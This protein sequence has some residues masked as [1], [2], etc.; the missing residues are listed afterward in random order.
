MCTADRMKDRLDNQI[1]SGSEL[2]QPILERRPGSSDAKLLIIVCNEGSA[3]ALSGLIEPMQFANQTLGY[4][5]YSWTVAGYPG[6][7]VRMNI[8]LDLCCEAPWN[9]EKP[10]MNAVVI[11]NPQGV[12]TLDR[13]KRKTLENKLRHWVRHGTRLINVDM[14]VP[15]VPVAGSSELQVCVHWKIAHMIRELH[16]EIEVS[17]NLYSVCGKVVFSAGGCAVTDLVLRDISVTHG[18]NLTEE[19]S[20]LML[21]GQARTGLARQK[22]IRTNPDGIEVSGLADVL[23]L[24]ENNIENPLS[25][26]QI[27]E[28]STVGS[29]RHL[30]RLFNR[31]FGTTPSAYY[32]RLRLYKARSLVEQTSWCLDEIAAICGFSGRSHM[33]NSFRKQFGAEPS[34]FRKT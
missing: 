32:R 31:N 13:R 11:G 28:Q 30:E 24:M 18:F 15:I 20:D 4:D 5:A 29:R 6:D 1:A 27:C 7:I 26:S 21:R 23:Q 34:K 9:P 25:I 19:V 8:G 16:P 10:P 14:A 12:E 33:R 2:L 3:L 17:E 22:R